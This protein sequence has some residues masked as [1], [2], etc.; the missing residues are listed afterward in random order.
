MTLN[1]L[2]FKDLR[3]AESEEK[4]NAEALATLLGHIKAIL[5]LPKLSEQ[6][7]CTFRE[8]ITESDT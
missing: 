6:F 7:L 4:E 3:A 8:G 2:K 5:C 1:N